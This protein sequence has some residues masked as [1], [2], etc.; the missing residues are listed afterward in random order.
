MT[1]GPSYSTQWR[2]T[3]GEVDAT[4]TAVEVDFLSRVLP[5]PPYRSVLDVPCGAGRHMQG[6]V[7]R[8]Y[9]VVG[10]DSDEVVV[11]R[12]RAAGL[13]AHVGDMRALPE[14]GGFD[15]VICMWAIFGWFDDTT[16]AAV[17]GELA[18]RLRP[19]GRLVL[20]VYHRGFFEA[21]EG[22]VRNRGVRER[23]TVAAGRLV[24]ELTYRDG[25]T[26]RFEWTLFTPGELTALA[27]R[28]GL[29][30]VLACS[31]FDETMPPTASSPR[32]QLVFARG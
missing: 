32:M 12:A 2:A 30:E 22:E 6:L 25:V 28:H 31:G 1:A 27:A 21:H 23:K 24:T 29:V 13:D 15:A 20:D 11:A 26:D 7:A 16:N 10:V 8:G 19:G 9:R 5:L 18:A 14:L 4:R 17:L 3:F